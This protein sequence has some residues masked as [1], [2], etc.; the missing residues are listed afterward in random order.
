[1]RSAFLAAS[2]I[3]LGISLT[4]LNGCQSS[5]SQ[6]E[7]KNLLGTYSVMLDASPDKVTK[8]AQRALDDL[9]FTDVQATLSKVD[10]HLTAQTAQK[11]QIN[12]NVEQGG[13]N[14]SKMSIRVGT[15]GDETISKQIVEKT[16]SHLHWF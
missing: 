1:M 14:I 7:V 5:A 16:K 10:G 12:I 9:K 15:T 6:P 2:I 13:E 3:G 11:D 4:A 8:A